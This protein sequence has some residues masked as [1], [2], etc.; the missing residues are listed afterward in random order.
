MSSF[1]RRPRRLVVSVVA[2]LAA[3]GLASA[4]GVAE[5]KAALEA[6]L[7]TVTAGELREH[8][9]VLADDTLEGREAGSRGGRA[10]ARYLEGRLRAMG[11]QAGG[12]NGGYLQRFNPNYQNIL[13]VLPGA[14]P[15]LRT[16]YVLVGAHYDHVGY[17]SRRNS[18]GPVGFIHNGADDNA[19]GVAALLEV[20]D[21]LTKS[22]WQPRRSILF[23]FWD[24]EEI[25]LLGSRH[26]VREP[27]VPLKDVRLAINLDMVGR[28][29]NGRLEVG[30]TRTGFGLRR[31][32]STA[33]LPDEMWLDFTW[34]F[35]ENS[36]HWPLAEAGVPSLILH[37]GIHGDYHRPSDD[38]EKLNFE[39]I[40]Q[41]AAYLLEALCR[42]ADEDDLPAY[43]EAGRSD[44]PFMRRLREAPL[45]PLAPRLGLK[46]DWRAER[47]THRMLV[48]SVTPGSAAQ[49]AGL[50]VGDE[51][52]TI[53]ASAITNEEQLPAAV[54]RAASE[55]TLAVVREE[56]EAQPI[57]VPLDGAPV[58]LGISWR[59][60]PAAPGAVYV[61]RVVPFSPAGRAG[62]AIY[63]RIYTIEGESFAGQD[64][65][66]KRVK[67]R[68]AAHES[69]Q[70][71]VERAGRL[72]TV[73]VAMGPPA[74][75][76]EDPSL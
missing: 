65:L 73:A 47:E 55:I 40:Q 6:A 44:Y 66:L 57:R 36:D 5:R 16:E 20:M 33:N 28:M 62:I 39:G 74:A 72:R 24:G 31:L 67:E 26:W 19:S 22:G 51:I 60:D 10:A 76:M 42:V 21:A 13:A 41:S 58:E 37:T 53:D 52:K 68:L 61:T 3:A 64:D 14:D 49:R 43:R 12:A 56:E 46:W 17:G 27:T 7:A 30:G 9:G 18:N 35:K 75:A 71:E 25:N 29:K 4:S 63:D 70:F 69:I 1:D 11:L 48:A 38:M 15:K 50:R 32:L 59:E 54:L 2:F 45:A 23:S 34:E 8:A